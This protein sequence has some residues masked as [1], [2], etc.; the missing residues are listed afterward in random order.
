MP[1]PFSAGNA[2][3]RLFGP[4]ARGGCRYCHDVV[5]P[6]PGKSPVDLWKITKP[7]IPEH[8]MEHSRFRHRSHEFMKCRECHSG[9]DASFSTGDVLMPDI[10]LCRNCHGQHAKWTSSKETSEPLLAGART[11]CVECHVYHHAAAH[12]KQK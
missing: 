8:W 5:E 10:A 11:H 9:V 3:H 2:E 4:E 7:R 12:G 1:L 6:S